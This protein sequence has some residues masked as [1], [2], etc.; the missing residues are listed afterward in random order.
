M[1][2]QCADNRW[3]NH[4]G[5]DCLSDDKVKLNKEKKLKNRNYRNYYE[6]ERQMKLL[7]EENGN[8]AQIIKRMDLLTKKFEAL[9]K[10]KSVRSESWSKEMNLAYEELKNK[11]EK[12]MD[13]EILNQLVN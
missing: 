11:I 12:E 6:E 8:T 9:K 3:A 10:L 2:C 5:A 1:D 7:K 4:Q 13:K